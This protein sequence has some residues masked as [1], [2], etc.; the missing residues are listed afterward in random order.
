[1]CE[2]KGGEG[3]GG[4]GGAWLLESSMHLQQPQIEDV[5]IVEGSIK[6][7]FAERDLI[8]SILFRK[9]V[10]FGCIFFFLANV[11]LSL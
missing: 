9:R 2:G 3:G 8:N 10:N 6:V 11:L 1:M 5:F 4:Q 7:D